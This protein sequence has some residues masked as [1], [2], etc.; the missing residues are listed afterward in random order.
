MKII[1][2][3]FIIATST[4]VFA[5]VDSLIVYDDPYLLSGDV[6]IEVSGTWF[7]T[8][9]PDKPAWIKI[10]NS[11]INLY[12]SW[13][14]DFTPGG[15][16]CDFVF[17]DYDFSMNTLYIPV[18]SGL[19]A[20]ITNLNAFLFTP[21]VDETPIAST[22]ISLSLGNLTD[23]YVYIALEGGEVDILSR[24]N[25]SQIKSIQFPENI[26]KLETNNGHYFNFMS[27]FLSERAIGIIDPYLLEFT[28]NY[29]IVDSIDDLTVSYD[30]ST[31]QESKLFMA[32]NRT[33]DNQET[34]G[35]FGYLDGAPHTFLDSFVSHIYVPITRGPVYAS[36]QE[37]NE[38]ILLDQFTMEEVSKITTGSQPTI[39]S[40]H[41]NE[42]WLMLYESGDRALALLDLK[43]NVFTG[44]ITMPNEVKGIV[45][46][47]I[48]PYFYA[49][50]VFNNL[51]VINAI[52]MEIISSIQ[53]DGEVVGVSV[54]P[55]GGELLV[56][57]NQ[58]NET[59]LITVLESQEFSEIERHVLNSRIVAVPSFMSVPYWVPEY[60]NGP[61]VV[62]STS[63]QGT[64][65]L[66]LLILIFAYGN[67][68][69]QMHFP[70]EAS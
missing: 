30:R 70:I 44:R 31:P 48:Q 1:C 62:P 9:K 65:L 46:D 14:V 41:L 21:Q 38:I 58:A 18:D 39:M 10:K 22:P 67:L 26:I 47:A 55:E 59:G 23:Q 60:H 66:M 28:T 32:S 5:Q 11:S 64:L 6:S 34:H 43:S 42:Q 15:E 12:L 50:D 8:C 3:L 40:S 68:S 17:V 7:D 54:N 69:K 24:S 53:V 33:I 61:I 52:S 13:L 25:F 36:M 2:L 56:F 51:S 4:C 29:L 45:S 63:Y 57:S 19:Q 27:T 37:D 20:G 35:V 49:W 16:A